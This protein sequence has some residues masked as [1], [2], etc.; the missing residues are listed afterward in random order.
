MAR[1]EDGID[2]LVWNF[3]FRLDEGDVFIEMG[4][5]S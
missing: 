5:S 2:A 3:S 1:G 4:A